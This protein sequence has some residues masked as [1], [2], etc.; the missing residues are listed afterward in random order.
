MFSTR[1]SDHEALLLAIVSLSDGKLHGITRLQKISLLISRDLEKRSAETKVFNDWIADAYGGRST[2]VYT[3]KDKLVDSQILEETEVTLD[4][5][6]KLKQY[7]VTESGAILVPALKDQLGISWPRIV[8]LMQKYK[9]VGTNQLIALAYD[10]YPELT[11]H[12][13]IKPEVNRRLVKNHSG[14]SPAYEEDVGVLPSGKLSK[15]KQTMRD[16]VND[17]KF[18]KRREYEMQKLPD[19]E[20]RKRMAR[21]AG[22]TEVPKLD[23]YA[24]Y[25]LRGII[26]KNVSDEEFDSV[27]MVRA[28]R[29]D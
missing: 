10:L 15:K 28:V 1:L 24:I 2:L 18:F 25:N 17:E 23:P 14:L 5:A 8:E 26:A 20:A 4:K 11:I 19:M 7:R 29:G 6:R 22:L 13:K 27:E 3:M 21:I 9:R 16:Q 12:S